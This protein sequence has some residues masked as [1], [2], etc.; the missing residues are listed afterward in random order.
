MA[1]DPISAVAS[2]L[3]PE[4]LDIDNQSAASQP[5]PD[6]SLLA[7][8]RHIAELK[9][10]VDR[11]PPEQDVDTFARDIWDAQRVIDT[12]APQTLVGAAVKLRRLATKEDDGLEQP[13][14]YASVRQVLGVVERL[15][16]ASSPEASANLVDPLPAMSAE[17]DR[18]WEEV[19]NGVP[20]DDDPGDDDKM[21]RADI[22]E[23]L[24]I[25]M[26]AS[27]ASGIV[28]QLKL[29]K[30]LTEIVMLDGS[31]D[32]E[33]RLNAT[34]I[35]GVERLAGCASL[36]SVAPTAADDTDPVLA[37]VAEAR[38]LEALW[39]AADGIRGG[40]EVKAI[41]EQMVANLSQIYGTKPVTIGGAI[42]MLEL[43]LDHGEV[44]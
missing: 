19:G 11:T 10:A 37:L 17:R 21:L 4:I 33:E 13:L 30:E 42:A 9:A 12:T 22:I 6:A 8:A 20:G 40:P 2:W 44:N 15:I 28:A 14:S 5:A 43:G 18:L 35:A 38:R 16:E 29:A 27:S 26:V 36:T 3:T 39:C 31:D 34:I 41:D 25:G 23:E 7:A 24:I 1:H 32:R